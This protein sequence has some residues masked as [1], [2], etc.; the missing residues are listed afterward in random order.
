MSDSERLASSRGAG[1][2]LAV[3]GPGSSAASRDDAPI[4]T[5]RV[6]RWCGRRYVWPKG[7]RR[8]GGVGPCCQPS[9]FD[10][11]APGACHG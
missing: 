6:C 1:Q 2:S 10:R 7:G 11:S 8:P 9:L 4:F 3:V 5:P